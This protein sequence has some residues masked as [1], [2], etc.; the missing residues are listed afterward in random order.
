[1]RAVGAVRQETKATLLAEFAL[2]SCLLGNCL[3]WAVEPPIARTNVV[4]TVASGPL[5]ADLSEKPCGEGDEDCTAGFGMI[6]PSDDIYFYDFGNGNI[7]VIP[8]HSPNHGHSVI[9]GLPMVPED[10]VGM[11]DGT[12]FLLGDRWNRG[13]LEAERFAIHQWSPKDQKWAEARLQIE[14]EDTV[15][16][17]VITYEST[18]VVGTEDGDVYIVNKSKD[19]SIQVAASNGLVDLAKPLLWERRRLPG[20][21]LDRHSMGYHTSRSAVDSEGRMYSVGLQRNAVYAYRHD[22]EGKVVATIALPP[23][24]TTKRFVGKGHILVSTR[25]T[26]LGLQIT[27]QGLEIS[28]MNFD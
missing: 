14:G 22:P 3:G 26:L 27:K 6:G 8:L 16:S 23:R 2:A 19:L 4:A 9:P 17:G 1:M 21:T 20:R 15:K 18:L 11:R 5:P 7:K 24:S 28:E 25:G 13:P 10:G 12:I